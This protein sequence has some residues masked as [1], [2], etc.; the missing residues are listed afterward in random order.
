LLYL[1][2]FFKK[3]KQ[4]LLLGMILIFYQ[5]HKNMFYKANNKI[6]NNLLLVLLDKNLITKFGLFYFKN[7]LIWSKKIY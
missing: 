6:N 5:I 4:N 7:I 3:N 1:D 2:N